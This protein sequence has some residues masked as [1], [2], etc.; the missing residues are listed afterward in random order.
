[1]K[2]ENIPNL[3]KELDLGTQEA[4]WM[5]NRI[6]KFTSR[7]IVIKLLKIKGGKISWKCPEKNDAV[8]I[9]EQ[10]QRPE[11]SGTTD[12]KF[13]KK[14]L[15]TRILYPMN[16]YIKNKDGKK[17]LANEGKLRVFIN[18]RLVLK[19]LLQKVLYTS[20]I[21]KRTLGTLGKK[22]EQQKWQTSLG[23]YNWLFH[24]RVL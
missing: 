6:N 22:K 13:W 4:Q 17:T 18:S 21:I 9:G 24:S 14:K 20:E 3:A 2:S 11:R 5:P 1:M 16:I 15:S 19:K 12:S 10:P 7:H 23:K 8:A